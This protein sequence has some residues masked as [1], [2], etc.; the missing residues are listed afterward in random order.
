MACEC[1]VPGMFGYLKMLLYWC[2]EISSAYQLIKH[3]F[4][5]S[6]LVNYE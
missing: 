3:Q 2:Y 4:I 1:I 5:Y 6:K